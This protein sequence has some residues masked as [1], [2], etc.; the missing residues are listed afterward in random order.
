MADEL[1]SFARWQIASTLIMT[2]IK[3]MRSAIKVMKEVDSEL[4]NIQKV[5]NA[6]A[7]EMK[8]LTKEAYAM[9]TAYGRSPVEFLKSV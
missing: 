2:P 8:N 4:V 6:T 3:A 1:K 9:A 7:E 5:T